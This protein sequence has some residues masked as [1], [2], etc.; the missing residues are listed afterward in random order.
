MIISPRFNEPIAAYK[1]APNADFF[2]IPIAECDEALL[3][4]S[5]VS[6]RILVHSAYFSAGIAGASCE[7][8]ARET[9]L[10]KL[11]YAAELLPQELCLVVL[12]GFRSTALQATL[13]QTCY[14]QFLQERPNLSKAELEELAVQYFARPSISPMAPS[15]HVTGGAMDVCLATKDG[16]EL[17]F[18]SVFDFP[19]RISDTRYFEELLD[20]GEPLTAREEEAMKNRRLLYSVMKEAGFANYVSEWWHFEYGTQRWAL[21]AGQ[22]V[23][24]Y[25]AWSL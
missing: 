4:L 11:L 3:P 12:D 2:Q 22:S 7:C 20:R 9:V 17:F 1:V 13:F 24:R 25:G 18:G 23:A 16:T 6:P 15:P 10:K 21:L 5:G 8:Y 19:Q 14:E